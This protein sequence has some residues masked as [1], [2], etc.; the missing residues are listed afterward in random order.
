MKN[1]SH[2][3]QR[4]SSAGTERAI[5]MAAHVSGSH[6][7]AVNVFSIVDIDVSRSAAAV[8]YFGRHEDKAVLSR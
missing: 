5:A 8:G 7:L 6:N 1:Y 2:W 4:T 3:K